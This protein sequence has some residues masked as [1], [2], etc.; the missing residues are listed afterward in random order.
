[1]NRIKNVYRR[2]RIE[3][4][5]KRDIPNYKQSIQKLIFE[6]FVFFLTAVAFAEDGCG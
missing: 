6:I 4:R 2:E 1:M 3:H 5:E